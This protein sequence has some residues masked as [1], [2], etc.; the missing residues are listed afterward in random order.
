MNLFS[1]KLGG[2]LADDEDLVCAE[3]E[4]QYIDPW[5]KKKIDVRKNSINF[6]S[7]PFAN[8][9]NWFAIGLL[10]SL[11]LIKIREAEALPSS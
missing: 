4:T 8:S 5:S 1:G 11:K 2:G 6:N 7:N 10:A 9:K 3:E